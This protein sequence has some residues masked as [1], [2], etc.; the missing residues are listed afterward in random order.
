MSQAANEGRL[1][2]CPKCESLLPEPPGCLVYECG[3]CGYESPAVKSRNGDLV[4]RG[5]SGDVNEGGLSDSAAVGKS[6]AQSINESIRWSCMRD[7]LDGFQ[8]S[9]RS[10]HEDASDSLGKSISVNTEGTARE[11]V[12]SWVYSI[13]RQ[14]GV[15]VAQ[16]ASFDE[17]LL[18]EDMNMYQALKLSSMDPI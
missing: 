17:V 10:I 5:L 12:G 9:A 2:R 4:E 1:V 3:G 11:K 15:G 18:L 14:E 7:A 13:R 8:S 16:R 6:P